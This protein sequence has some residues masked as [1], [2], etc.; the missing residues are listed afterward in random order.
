YAL[1][2]TYIILFASL[3]L[4][5]VLS[6]KEIKNVFR[7]RL[8]RY[9][10]S[11][12]FVA[13]LFFITFSALYVHP[14]EQ[15]YFDENI[16]QGIALNILHNANALWCQYGTA[17][18][19]QCPNSQIYHDPVEWSFY[20]AIAFAIFGV[21]TATAYGFQLFAGALSI[22][23]VFLLASI[24]FDKK[25]GAA[26]AVVFA[27]I[28]EIFIWSRTQMSPDLGMMMFSTLAFLCYVIYDRNKSTGT[29]SLFLSALAIS[30]YLRIEAAI[31]VP[32]FLLIYLLGGKKFDPIGRISDLITFDINK[33]ALV[34]FAFVLLL[35]PEVYYI[36]YQLN[37]LDYGSGYVC[38]SSSQS[39]HT[40]S[41]SY[42]SCNL[43]PNVG[44]FLG[45]YNA[46]SYY[47]AYFSIFTTVAAI[48]GLILLI[49]TVKHGK[50]EI[51]LM[52]GLWILSFHIFY[53][54]FYAGSITYGVDVR[55]MLQVYPPIAILAGVSIGQLG[56]W[57]IGFANKKFRRPR[58]SASKLAAFGLLSVMVMLLIFAIYPFVTAISAVTM[59]P[60][61]MPQQQTAFAATNFINANYNAV[62]ANCLV[63]SFTPDVWYE[64]NRSSAQIGMLGSPDP[65]FDAFA[66]HYSCFVIDY[67]FWCN[68]PPYQGSSCKTYSRY[69]LTVLASENSTGNHF[70]LYRI[71]NYTDNNYG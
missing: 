45:A 40:F 5:A 1:T 42:L 23:L 34:V 16:Y 71:N 70:A 67:G 25:V 56:P 63:F 39:N 2:A 14:V 37:N 7:G 35:L 15:L 21:G 65:S 22:I 9:S 59:P 55:F 52:L 26:S 48:L 49:L 54:F 61:D 20:L 27:L 43:G 41:L 18:A 12:A 32:I 6:F 8:D 3:V 19:A 44:F 46:H 66:S 60:S 33:S 4:S 68:V 69:N 38:S 17:Q 62:P 47:P 64:L 53:D 11:I 10:V 24:L 28:P 30:V 13:V 31:L 58:L 50:R 36:S 29:L 51:L 57:I